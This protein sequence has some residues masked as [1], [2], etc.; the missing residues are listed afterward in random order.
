MGIGV[1]DLR[2]VQFEVNEELSVITR[3]PGTTT[4]EERLGARAIRPSL[5]ARIGSAGEIDTEMR[6]DKA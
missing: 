2:A 1:R 3:G 4:P 6:D 5:A